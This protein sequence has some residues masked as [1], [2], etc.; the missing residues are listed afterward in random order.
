MINKLVYSYKNLPYPPWNKSETTQKTLGVAFVGFAIVFVFTW[1]TP[2]ALRL[3]RVQ[4]GV[5]P[6]DIP[7]YQ[8]ITKVHVNHLVAIF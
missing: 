6:I 3:R 8:K 2:K 1:L 5:Y 7:S 4:V